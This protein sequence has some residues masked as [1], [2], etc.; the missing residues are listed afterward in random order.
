MNT[1]IISVII[2]IVA[3]CVLVL[4][5][6]VVTDIGYMKGNMIVSG[7]PYWIGSII[8]CVFVPTTV[9]FALY[10]YLNEKN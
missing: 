3:F 5:F 4:M 6:Y 10:D 1:K 9:G 7:V 8:T 2:S